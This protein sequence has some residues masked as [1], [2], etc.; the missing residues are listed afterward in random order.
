MTPKQRIGTVAAFVVAL[1]SLYLLW[2][3][4]AAPPELMA[5]H[6]S[7]PLGAGPVTAAISATTT[8]DAAASE[9]AH[10]EALAAPE[11]VGRGDL[12]VRLFYG[13]DRSPAA[14][15]MVTAFRKHETPRNSSA[16]SVDSKRRRTDA[17]GIARFPSMRAGR[18]GLIA[19]RGHWYEKARVVAGK[20]TEV[21]FVMPVGVTITGIVVSSV[22]V[23]VVG[24]EV[25]LESTAV[26]TTDAA[27]RF[28]VRGASPHYSCRRW[29]SRSGVNS[30]SSAALIALRMPGPIARKGNPVPRRRV[31]I[32]GTTP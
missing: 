9:T 16:P 6:R 3:T 5:S 20:E 13:D 21:E 2:P 10:R 14:G 18:T 1:F 26:T 4:D 31:S 25:E 28:R 24:A 29:S 19:D 27:G 23:P 12:V 22:G 17:D 32:P 8:L 7:A 30:A 11:A 15:V